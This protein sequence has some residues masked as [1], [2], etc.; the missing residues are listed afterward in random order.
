MIDTVQLVLL[1]VIVILTM[2]L[3]ILGVQVYF[4]LKDLRG[5]VKKANKVLDTTNNITESVSGPIA[6][7]STLVSGVSTGTLV[8]KA[9]KIGLKAFSKRGEKD[10]DTRTKTT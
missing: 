10:D 4:I 2:L 3:V 8:A 6:S 9:L 1:L 7:V 5:T